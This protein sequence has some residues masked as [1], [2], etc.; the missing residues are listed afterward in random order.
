K[1]IFS[2]QRSSDQHIKQLNKHVRLP[3]VKS[4]I[5]K[6]K[7]ERRSLALKA[8]KKSSDE[9]CSTSGSKD[10]EYAM[11]VKDFKKFFKRRDLNHLIGECPKPPRDKNQRAF[12]RGSWSDSG[13]EDD[14]KIQDETCLVAQE[15]NEMCLGVDLEPDEWINDSGCS[16]HM[17][18]NRKLFSTYKA[19]NGGNVSFG[20]NLHGNIIN[21]GTISNDSLKIDNVEHVDNLGFNLLS[22]GQICDIKCRVTFFEHDS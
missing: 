8:K 18:G 9:E 6:S 17:T 16:K 14:E 2:A 19:Y 13:E 22:I 1:S 4:E 3:E 21:K 11:A 20:S 10:E 7:G 5:V 12:V 15:P